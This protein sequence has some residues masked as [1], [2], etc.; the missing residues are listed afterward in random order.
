MN[1][2]ATIPVAFF[3]TQS[4]PFPELVRSL[5]LVPVPEPT[6][7]WR[8]IDARRALRNG[9]ATKYTE[10]VPGENENAFL[11]TPETRVV[12]DYSA[13]Q[14]KFASKTGKLIAVDDPRLDP[15]WQEC[16]RLGIPVSIHVSDP[17]AFFHPNTRSPGWALFG[18]QLGRGGRSHQVRAGPAS[19]QSASSTKPP[20]RHS[21]PLPPTGSCRRTSWSS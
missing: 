6:R 3:I 16:G 4:L 15:V 12:G 13:R 21:K 8:P 11:E 5:R 10:K 19:R 2:R 7:T 20:W 18:R 9:M 17:E 14:S 1:Q